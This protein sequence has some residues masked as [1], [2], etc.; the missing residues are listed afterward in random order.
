[1]TIINDL[2][3]LSISD[4]PNHAQKPKTIIRIKSIIGCS[5][6]TLIIN[7]VSHTVNELPRP[8]GRGSSL[9]SLLHLI[10]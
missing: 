8:S 1:M 7:A 2:F 10:Y 4:H 9:I 3:H 5:L 6:G